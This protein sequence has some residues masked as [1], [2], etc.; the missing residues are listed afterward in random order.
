[1]PDLRRILLV[2]DEFFIAMSLEAELK[3]SGAFECQQVATGEEAVTVALAQSPDLIVMDIGLPGQIDGIEAAQ[4]ILA[5]QSVPLIFLTGYPDREVKQRADKLNPL[6]YFTK[7]VMPQE[8]IAL[9]NETF[10]T[11]TN[12]ET[13]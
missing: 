1:M 11:D 4:R 13:A 12:T 5:R 6:G 7:P 9:I 3:Q 8:L 2:E 10:S